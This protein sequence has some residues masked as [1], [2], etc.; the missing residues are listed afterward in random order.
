MIASGNGA[1]PTSR[2][3][4]SEPSAG[5]VVRV[6][7]DEPALN[8]TFDYLLPDALAGASGVRLGTMVRVP[9]HGRRVGA[10]VVGVNVD[11]AVA[12]EQLL[13]VAKVSSD[14]PP[15][16][17]L[18]LAKWASWRWWGRPATFLSIGSPK[19]AVHGG[20]RDAGQRSAALPPPAVG[21]ELAAGLRRAFERPVTSVV[22]L[23]P[24]SDPFPLLI[25]ALRA[26]HDRGLL[27][28]TP[29][30]T[31][32]HDL[33][34]RFRRLGVRVAFAPDDWANATIPGTVVVGARTA[35]WAPVADFGVAVVLDEHDEAYQDERSPT[36]HAREVVV[37]RAQRVGSPCLLVSPVPSPHA[38]ALA[39]GRVVADDRRTERGTWPVVSLLDRS[40]E[41]PGRVPMVAPSL[42]A[43]LRSSGRVVCVL[44]RSGRAKLLD[45]RS[46]GA[47]AECERCGS[48]MQQ[49]TDALELECGRCGQRAPVV[50]RV[51][52]GGRLRHLRPGTARLREDLEAL[53]QRPVVEVVGGVAPTGEASVL[54]GTEAVLHAA[55]RADV[56]VALDVDGELLA[57]RMRAADALVALVLRCARLVGSDG[58][59][60]LVTRQPEHPI[61]RALS[62]GDGAGL[63]E[64]LAEPLRTL[65]YAPPAVVARVSGAGAG[66][67]AE[68]IGVA[69]KANAAKANL[70]V[71]RVGPADGPFLLRAPS[72]REL[73]DLLAEVERPGARVRV[74]VDPVRW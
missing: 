50:C 10:W 63:S 22:R 51:C 66:A 55:G 56:V 65:G 41:E 62:L 21:V 11:P 61:L 70:G 48:A 31:S 53:A 12:R 35:A 33:V 24:V 18:S 40:G 17:L 37:E 3:R 13:A 5:R 73:A 64:L 60:V 57:P 32:A 39:D 26:S 43:T 8:K 69:T 59:V 49:Q 36:W 15:R 42:T 71:E 45:C 6:L 19:R 28:L 47:L 58:R 20:F 2:A 29:Q 38:M 14:G 9:L 25:E 54:V 30:V 72:I 1:N 68:A 52:G 67:V 46:C 27:V 16:E 7:P 23:G 74:E 34:R 4:P 44:N